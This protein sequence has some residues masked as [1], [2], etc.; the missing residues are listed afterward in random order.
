MNKRFDFKVTRANHVHQG[1]KASVGA[2][3]LS[4]AIARAL[5]HIAQYNRRVPAEEWV[6]ELVGYFDP[7]TGS[8]D[9]G[10]AR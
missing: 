4:E 5:A 1:G 9:V 2:T 3:C 7:E 6:F 10:D 8:H